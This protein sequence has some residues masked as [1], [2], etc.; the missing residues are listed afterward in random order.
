MNIQSMKL[1]AYAFIAIGVAALYQFAPAL[2]LAKEG[3]CG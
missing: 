1:L 2:N 3:V